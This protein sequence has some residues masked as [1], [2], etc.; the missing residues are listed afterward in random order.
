MTRKP[1]PDSTDS[2]G[3][4]QARP[5]PNI[6]LIM[7]DDMGYSDIGCYGGE[8][9]TPQLNRLARGGVSFS[10]MYNCARCCPTRA[11]ILTGLY[12]H[13][14]GV[15]GMT[16]EREFAGYRGYLNDSCVTIAEALKAGGYRT[17][18]SGKWHCGGAYVPREPETWTPGDAKHPTPVT[19]G[20][21]EH[22][23]MLA[24]AGSYYAPPTLC[25]NDTFIKPDEGFYFTDAIS[26][27]AVRMIGL[28]PAHDEPF[29]L[30]VAYTAPHWPLHAPPED[31]GRYRGRYAGGWDAARTARHERLKAAGL[32]DARWPI[33]PR[34]PEAPPW[35]DVTDKDMQD[36]RMAVYAAQID[37]MDQGVGRIL[38]KLDELGIADDTMVM[39]L[40]DNGGCHEFLDPE[41]PWMDRLNTSA[42]D[43]RPMRMGNLPDVEPGPAETYQS[44][45]RPWANVSNTPFRL[46]KHWVHEGGIATPLIV[47]W[48]GVAEGGGISHAI[49]HVID[50]L[51]TCLDAA[52]VPYPE[53]YAGRPVTPAAGRSMMPFV[54]G[55]S[56]RGGRIVY[57]EHEGNLAVRDGR[58]KLVAKFDSDRRA[59]AP[60]ELYDMIADRT[61]LNDLAAAIPDTVARLAALHARWAHSIGV[62][63][64]ER[65]IQR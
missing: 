4:G 7:V 38:D 33:S 16:N 64:W 42:P 43:G 52:G 5:R 26:G 40:S 61:E 41:S 3:A 37:R 19:R 53:Q 56:D 50:V 17:Y 6:V 9:R 62:V 1:S 10:Q 20:F 18:M 11:S 27:H 8:I 63:P 31:I 45:Q 47:R 22:F 39:F 49:G 30:Y 25:H 44:Y 65:L 29:F 36:H 24:G 12:P 46:H 35:D 32:L 13:Q 54:R 2:S 59:T 23:G 28:A 15:G 48:P 21:D 57:W 55:Q 34:D 58:W 60:W 14:A 51:P